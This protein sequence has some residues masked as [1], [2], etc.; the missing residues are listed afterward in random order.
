MNP[1]G[2][3]SS[4]SDTRTNTAAKSEVRRLPRPP[5]PVDRLS[6]DGGAGHLTTPHS[7]APRA[8]RASRPDTSMFWNRA[9]QVEERRG[10][11]AR[12]KRRREADGGRRIEPI[13]RDWRLPFY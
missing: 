6:D 5:G 2:T 1:P 9:S 11:E 10:A 7:E 3:F 4:V 13:R 8:A 12:S